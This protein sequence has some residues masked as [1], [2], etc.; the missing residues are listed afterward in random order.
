MRRYARRIVTTLLVLVCTLSTSLAP[1]RA[2]LP[3]AAAVN[4]DT[5]EIDGQDSSA[6]RAFAF[7]ENAG[8]F[9]AAVRFQARAGGQSLWLTNDAVWLTATSHDTCAVGSTPQRH[10][11]APVANLKLSFIGANPEAV[12]QASDPLSGHVSYFLGS[13]PSAWRSALPLWATVRYRDLY[14]GIDLELSGTES[15]WTWRLETG[16]GASLDNVRLRIEGAGALAVEG[17]RVRASSAAGDFLIPLLHTTGAADGQAQFD[18]SQISAPAS[19]IMATTD[20]S[21]G[22]F[23]GG[24]ESDQMRGVAVDADGNAYVAGLT[25]S[26]NFTTT[27]G[28]IQPGYLDLTDAFVLKLDPTGSRLLYGTYFGGTDYEFANGIAV[29]GSGNAYI[30]GETV[31]DDLPVTAGSFSASH[32]ALSDAFVAGLN[33]SGT[34]LLYSTYLGGSGND[35]GNS[36]ALDSAGNAYVTG[37]TLSANFPTTAGAL[38]TAFNA[39]GRSDAFVAKLNPQG[40]AL[41]YSTFLGHEN[42]DIGHAVAVDGKGRAHVAGETKSTFFPTSDTGFDRTFNGGADAFVAKLNPDGSRLAYSTFLGAGGDER[43]YALA[44]DGGGFAYVSGE[45][46]SPLFPTTA[47]AYDAT[48]NGGFVDAFVTKVNLAGSA[49]VYS[50]F[51]GGEMDERALGISVNGAGSAYVTGATLSTRFPTTADAYKRTCGS[52]GACD[53]RD[54]YSYDDVFLTKLNALGAKLLY[55]TYAGGNNSDTGYAVAA[56]GQNSVF[57]AGETYSGDF[58]VSDSAFDTTFGG[59][60]NGFSDGFVARLLTAYVQRVN[61]GGKA[62]RDAGGEKWVADRMYTAGA[63]G[64]TSG[65][66]NTTT[67]E[68]ANTSD[69]MLY[70]TDRSFTATAAPG[71]RFTVPNGVYLVTLK[72]AETLYNAAGVRSFTVAAEGNTLLA[73]YDIFADAGAKNQAVADQTFSVIVSDGELDIDF[74]KI[75]GFRQPKINAIKVLQIS[76]D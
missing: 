25:A 13:D 50:T 3:A 43:A 26:L 52:D 1:G 2:A 24:S 59:F 15:G 67:A 65:I 38:D 18:G 62:F 5:T 68:I 35:F 66:T 33:A 9:P 58:P 55:S 17:A 71:Y 12:L 48:Y 75:P 14:P 20:L 39:S 36:I 28:V 72:F 23:L 34:A 60:A 63:W 32:S 45:T 30:V 21:L 22:A 41:A 11:Q 57:V 53:L 76:E 10:C 56:W 27:T 51:L 73:A 31:S 69:D 44:L 47:G 46:G 74:V 40:S 8:Q 49:L 29:D 64:Y 7:V 4:V 19:A 6:A 42:V 70:R 16:L 61:C 54:G 37:E